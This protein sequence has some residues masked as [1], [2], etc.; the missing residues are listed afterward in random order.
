MEIPE[1]FQVYTELEVAGIQYHNKEALKFVSKSGKIWLEFERDDAN[2]SDTNAIK[3][4]GCSEG[5]LGI[6]RVFLGF[7]PKDDS[8]RI[9]EYGLSTVVKPR[10]VK[11]YS[12]ADGLVEITFQIIGPSGKR[13]EFYPRG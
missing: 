4:L 1:G 12:G 11:V 6:R 2:A 9:V 7:I 10:L 8:V 3:I 13:C 5:V